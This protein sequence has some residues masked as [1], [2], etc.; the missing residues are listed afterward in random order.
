MVVVIDSEPVTAWPLIK[1]YTRCSKWE[2]RT[3]KERTA[4]NLRSSVALL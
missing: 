4:I 2:V 1:D 3:T